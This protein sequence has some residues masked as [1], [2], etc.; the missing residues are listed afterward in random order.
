M[1][2]LNA[3]TT[4]ELGEGIVRITMRDE[5]SKNTFSDAIID[6]L[7][8]QFERIAGREDCKV[9]I[10]T[11]YGNYFASG[12]TQ[13]A[14]LYLSEGKGTFAEISARKGATGTNLYS[15]ALECPV[16]VI[17]AMQGHGV[18]GG[19]VMGLFAD[20]VVLARES[21]YTT[22]FM[23]YGFTPGM[24]ATFIVPE[25]LG[26]VLGG[27]LLL[28]AKSYYGAELQKRGVPFP[29]V[30]RSEV[31]D[32][33]LE[34]ARSLAEK[35][36]LSLVTLKAHLVRGI[37]AQLADVIE[38]ELTMHATTFEQPEVRERIKVLFGN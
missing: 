18:G 24:G 6:G 14:L 28:T 10:L 7:A 37:R 22:N 36:R 8:T 25:K 34:L 21:L 3:V 17:S 35:P 30:P 9:V 38:R 4:E 12:G 20:F 26:P 31:P 29:V 19:F 13:E 23:K 5:Q 1:N 27:E 33:A 2:P 16:P 32:H 11:G 15:L